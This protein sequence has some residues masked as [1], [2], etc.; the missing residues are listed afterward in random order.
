MYVNMNAATFSRFLLAG[1]LFLATQRLSAQPY[2]QVKIT[3]APSFEVA[4]ILK[5]YAACDDA[6][7]CG[8]AV[9]INVNG[10]WYNKPTYDNPL[11]SIET[12]G[13]W[14][15]NVATYPPGDVYATK[16]AAF[17]VPLSASNDVPILDGKPLPE[18]LDAI[19][20][21]KDFHIQTPIDFSGREWDVK[22]T[23]PAP[24]G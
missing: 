23:V 5:G 17:L 24:L 2:P 13:L 18:A 1:A 19:A 6:E 9:Y 7:P 14:N 16:Y 20:L 11:T 15:C 21:A 3:N 12:N 22:A 10:G 4:G 8:I